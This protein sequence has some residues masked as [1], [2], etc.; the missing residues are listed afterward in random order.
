VTGPQSALEPAGQ[1]AESLARLFW[2]M[3]A[4]AAVIW[5]IVLGLALYAAYSPESRDLRGARRLIVIGGVVV[6]SVLLTA[7]LGYG[8]ALLPEFLA[9]APEN[10]LRVVVRGEQY[11]WRV[12]YHV[13]GREPIELANELRLPVN[14]PV[15]LELES[16]DVI[17]SFWVP[18]LAGKVDMI[19]GRRTRLLLVPTRTGNYRGVCAEYCGASH[20]FMALGVVVQEKMEFEDWLARQGAPARAAGDA[21]ARAGQELFLA[22]G[23]GA[24]H[25]VRGSEADG[26]VGPDLTHVG[27]RL[28]LA[29]G[30]LDSDRAAFARWVSETKAIKPGVHMPAFGMLPQHD[31]DAL[32]AYLDGL[33]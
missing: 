19:P 10:S 30:L 5:L 12:R 23:C 3:T 26:L 21:L 9:P 16:A 17:H 2:Q 8:L 11:W 25:A 27:G 28:S 4:G 14:E 6:P 32:A 24:C 7:L 18:A 22:Q 31:L 33:E 1:Q 20:A 15:E 29:A 13:P